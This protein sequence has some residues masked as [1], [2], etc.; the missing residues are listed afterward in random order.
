LFAIC[1]S[2]KSLNPPY[3]ITSFSPGKSCLTYGE[4]KMKP[5]LGCP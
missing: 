1:R 3:K 5:R 4:L 2:L